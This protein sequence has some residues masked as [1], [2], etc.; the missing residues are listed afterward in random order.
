M[1]ENVYLIQFDYDG[2]THDIPNLSYNN[3]KDDYATK[4][5]MAGVIED[6]IKE[7]KIHQDGE[8]VSNANLIGKG[9][10]VLAHVD[11]FAELYINNLNFKIMEKENLKENEILE[12]YSIYYLRNNN[13]ILGIYKPKEATWEDVFIAFITSDKYFIL[14]PEGNSFIGDKDNRRLFSMLDTYLS[15]C[16]LPKE[17]GACPN[18]KVECLN[19]LDLLKERLIAIYNKH[20]QK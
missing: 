3:L 20:N 1:S 2:K 9:C 18:E 6:Y 19:Q 4:L 16:E 13:L 5:W 11:D 7:N 17:Y 12:N 10:E 14:Q 15:T 8:K